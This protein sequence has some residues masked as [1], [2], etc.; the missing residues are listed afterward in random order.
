MLLTLGLLLVIRYS[1]R[2]NIYVS[3]QIPEPQAARPTVIHRA[4]AELIA[5]VNYLVAISRSSNDALSN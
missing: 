5:L 2:R 4:L 1:Y 3:I